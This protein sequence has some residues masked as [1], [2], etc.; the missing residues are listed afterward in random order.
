MVIACRLVQMQ[1]ALQ[2]LKLV[3]SS[4]P[5]WQLLTRHNP[6]KASST[7]RCQLSLC[8][9]SVLSYKKVGMHGKQ[10]ATPVGQD[11]VAV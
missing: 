1:A 11:Y 7:A 10:W 9:N 8:P 2:R 4:S 3:I 5:S 6:L